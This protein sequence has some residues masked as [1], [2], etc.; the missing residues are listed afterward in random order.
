M[1]KKVALFLAT[2][3][4]IAL[5]TV[6]LINLRGKLPDVEIDYGDKIFHFLAYALLCW[7]WYIV[8]YFK[9]NLPKRKAIIRAIILSIFFG[10]L[11]E[12]LQGTI[13]S[14]RSFD[15]YDAIAN[16]LGALLAGSLLLMKWRIQ[17]KN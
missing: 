13:T 6:S 8:F 15:V 11:L 17:V 3:Y 2:S 16:S 10:M 4:T 14:H 7:L 1:L 12:V 5:A 9:Q